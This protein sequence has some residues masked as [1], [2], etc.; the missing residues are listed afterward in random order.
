[1]ELRRSGLH[2]GATALTVNTDYTLDTV[3]GLVRILP[4]SPNATPGAAVT[5]DFTFDNYTYNAAAVGA[6]SSVNAYVLF[7][8]DPVKGRKFRHEYWNVMFTPSGQLGF[9][10]DDFLDFSLEGQVIADPTNHPT[11]PIGLVTQIG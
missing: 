1:V 7:I 11:A 9:I 4:T 5:A 3:N 6:V 10:K 2:A 8:G